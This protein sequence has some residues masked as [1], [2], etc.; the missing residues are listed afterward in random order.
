MTV[1]RGALYV[2]GHINGLEYRTNGGGG[3]LTLES[4]YHA[5][6]RITPLGGSNYQY[7]YTIK[8]H[9][10]NARLTFADLNA[11]SIV[12]VPGD[13]L[14]E[15]HYYPFGMN[16]SYGWMNNTGLI[17]NRYQYNGKELN[18]DFGLN[19][20]DYGARWYDASVGRWWS[21]DPLAN[22]FS[23]TTPYNSFLSN[24]LNIVDIQGDSSW[25]VTRQW[26]AQDFEGYSDFVD[27]EIKNM[28]TNAEEFDCAD[29]ATTL[30][31][32][33]SSENNLEVSFTSVDGK[34]ISSSSDI[35]SSPEEFEKIVKQTTNAKSIM[36]DMEKIMG[37]PKPGYMTNNGFHVNIVTSP[38]PNTIY[39][40][41]VPSTSGSLPAR[42][43][44]DSSVSPSSTFLRWDV[45]SEAA[46]SA[47]YEKK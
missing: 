43:P 9:L 28:K 5:E 46:R 16:M 6:G 25:P 13:I 20:N 47:Y 40:S 27:S 4:I 17:D 32:R 21:V 18:D 31:I 11:N 35:A 38:D 41:E 3:T 2:Q 34:A 15:N 39:G 37:I 36:N 29:L 44:K 10:G 8:D 14:Q 33:Y 7:E 45:I 30:L 22:K 42:V 12:D 1:E 19:W 26:D 23:N 24:P